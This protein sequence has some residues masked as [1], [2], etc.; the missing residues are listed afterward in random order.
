MTK[1]KYRTI[2]FIVALV[3]I[4][5]ILPNTLFAASYAIAIHKAVYYD[6]SD[7]LEVAGLVAASDVSEAH[8]IAVTL[9]IHHPSKQHDTVII[10]LRRP[11]NLQ[12]LTWSICQ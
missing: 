7:T 4:L 6:V 12:G 8:V 10:N 3:I 2:N 9:E 11:A 1:Q 5:G